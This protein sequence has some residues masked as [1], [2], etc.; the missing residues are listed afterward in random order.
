MG[1][2]I[3]NHT[4]IP[5][6]DRCREEKKK[7]HVVDAENGILKLWIALGFR[8][9]SQFLNGTSTVSRRSVPRQI[10]CRT[11]RDQTRPTNPTIQL[12]NKCGIHRECE[13]AVKASTLARIDFL[14]S[15][16]F[17]DHRE[18][19]NF[20]LGSPQC[21]FTVPRVPDS[22]TWKRPSI[23][24]STTLLAIRIAC[25]ILLWP[26]FRVA[27]EKELERQNILDFWERSQ[28]G[29]STPGCE[30]MGMRRE[31]Q[32]RLPRRGKSIG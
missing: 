14:D 25:E 22:L 1:Q 11:S 30:P 23:P 6:L 31:T 21:S 32:K 9:K 12:R 16:L 17:C 28:L 27:P 8:E 7:K 3:Y 5:R 19:G 13:R 4:N 24:L 20:E 26:S 18:P 15:K 29:S 2:N 10:R